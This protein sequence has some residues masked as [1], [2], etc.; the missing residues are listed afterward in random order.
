MPVSP[1]T[2]AARFSVSFLRRR[3]GVGSGWRASRSLASSAGGRWWLSSRR[4]TG[5]GRG[6]AGR[7]DNSTTGRCDLK[8]VA[9]VLVLTLGAGPAPALPARA[10][11]TPARPAEGG[12][13]RYGIPPLSPGQLWVTSVPVGLEVR[14]GD[15]PRVA[16]V[17]RT[18]LV[19]D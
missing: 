9:S 16:P 17:G 19:L 13:V 11:P 10:R 12:P 14:L 7:S 15:D 5:S 8:K 1:S 2:S 18:P 6:T 3:R 4:G